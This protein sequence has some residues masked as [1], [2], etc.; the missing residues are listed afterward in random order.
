[1]RRMDFTV[2]ERLQGRTVGQALREC[3]VSV[4]RVRS[5]KRVEGGI[6][7]DGAPVHTNVRVTAGQVISL[8][9][10]TDERPAAASGR[11][12]AVPYWDDCLMVL[13]KPAGL[14]VHPVKVYRDDTLAGAFAAALAARGQAAAFRPLN[15]LDR[16]TSGLVA[17]ALDPVTAA[18]LSGKVYK[19]Y[20]AIV[21]GRLPG[22]GRV[23]APLGA[24]E[25]GGIR[26]EV[27]AG[28]QPAVT[29][30]QTLALSPTHTLLRLRLQTGRTH[31]IRA[32]MAYL[33]YP[34]E[35]DDLY[36]GA[37]PLLARHAL[38]CHRL[39]LTHPLTGQTVTV[40]SPLPPDM[41]AFAAI[42]GWAPPSE[43]DEGEIRIDL[44]TD[45]LLK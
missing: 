30:W 8:A 25:G 36:G 18:S 16:N 42:Q 39:W 37:A 35:G 27:A 23:D 34:L 11:K 40:T 9:L 2:D 5:L 1:M 3:G 43:R 32:H 24:C 15:R 10:P 12:V 41:A 44:P 28:G 4:T 29:L 17:A 31:Q 20:W 6:T 45:F 13:D 19:E 38:H 21:K 7:L 33:G 26:R 14:P 22:R